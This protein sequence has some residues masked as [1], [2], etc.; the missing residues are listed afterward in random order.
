MFVNNT[1]M[2]N[3]IY[4]LLNT[5]TYNVNKKN[6][7]I[8]FIMKPINDNKKKSRCV[9]PAINV[10]NL[11]YFIIYLMYLWYTIIYL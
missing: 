10:D 8:V 11:T 4:Y 5:N 9:T 3:Q 2:C 7:L 6:K 1:T